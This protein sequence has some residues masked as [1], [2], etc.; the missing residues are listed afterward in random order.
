MTN[1]YLALTGKINMKMKAS[2]VVLVIALMLPAAAQGQDSNFGNWLIYIGNKKINSKWDLHNEV[3]YRNYNVIGDLEQLLL[4][5]GV[6]YS[7]NERKSNIL[8]GYGYILSENYIENTDSK[9]SVNEHRIFQQFISKQSV[10][11]VKL[12]HRYRFEQ[13]FVESD[14]NLRFRYFLGINIP[15]FYTEEEKSNFYLSIYNEIFL[16]TESPIFDRNRLYGGLGYQ[17][18]KNIKLEAGYMNQFFE[19]SSRDQF[20]IISFVNF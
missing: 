6:G 8:L 9:A 14:F 20:N 1:A 16:N 3:Q 15:L 13:R 7:F 5:T 11:Q 18:N 19:T 4:R 12:T 2:M 17:I 10:G